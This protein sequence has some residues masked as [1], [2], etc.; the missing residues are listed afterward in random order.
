M[1]PEAQHTTRALKAING[2]PIFI[3]PVKDFRV[4]RISLHQPV[5]VTRF[6]SFAGQLGS[7]SHIGISK[8][9]TNNLAGFFVARRANSQ[10]T[11]KP[12]GQ[13]KAVE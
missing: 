5:E 3:E 9:A 8:G 10:K 2:G 4:N 7:F 12:K 6:L 13:K 11:P 1:E